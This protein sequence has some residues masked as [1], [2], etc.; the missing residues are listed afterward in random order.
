ML[1]GV[2]VDEGA[3]VNVMT[4]PTMKYLGLK[5]DRRASVTL[6]M[7][8]KQIVRPEGVINNV[9]IPIMGVFTIVD[10]HV[11]LEEDGAYLMI[12]GRPWLT[13]SHA[14]NYWGE[15]YMTIGIH[16][17]RQ[18]VPFASFVKSSRGT[19]EYEDE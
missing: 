1:R 8:N 19:N 10:F 14:R 13:K 15:G 12:L 7:A 5:I 4:I 2:L 6:K 3:G 16:P 9:V 18:K 11:V 17:N